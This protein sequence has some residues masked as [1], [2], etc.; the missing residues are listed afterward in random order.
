MYCVAQGYEYKEMD[1]ASG[2]E[3]FVFYKP[4]ICFC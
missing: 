1:I 4:N 3:S 2:S